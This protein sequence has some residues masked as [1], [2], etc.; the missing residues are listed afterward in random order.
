MFSLNRLWNKILIKFCII[1]KILFY[2]G[3]LKYLWILILGKSSWPTTIKNLYI[4]TLKVIHHPNKLYFS[5]SFLPLH[6]YVDGYR[7]LEQAHFGLWASGVPI[8]NFIS[9]CYYMT[10][11]QNFQLKY[12]YIQG[13][14]KAYSKNI[15]WTNS[16][17]N[18]RMIPIL[19]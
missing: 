2:F 12:Q 18:H 15:F 14:Q 19:N 9:V 17:L 3:L 4:C 10:F 8:F 6:I 11:L 7:D 13:L 5:L 16:K 1:I